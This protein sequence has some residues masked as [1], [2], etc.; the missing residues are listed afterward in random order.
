MVDIHKA[1]ADL[2]YGQFRGIQEDAIKAFCE[3]RDVFGMMATSGGKSLCYQLPAFAL[4]GYS[5]VISPLIAL[6]ND[7]ADGMKGRGIP[8]IALTPD[9][10]LRQKIDAIQKAGSETKC[11]FISPELMETPH[12]LDALKRN[13]PSRAVMDE[14]HCIS[15]WGADFRPS[16]ML[17]GELIDS[18]S[19]QRIPRMA[20]T[21]TA[22]K[23]A[24]GDILHYGR[25]RN[26]VELKQSLV[27]NNIQIFMKP[28]T[29]SV[30]TNI[31]N[32]CH[33]FG[34]ESG[35]IYC[36]RRKDV[37]ALYEEMSAAGLK[38]AKH[39]SGMR[40]EERRDAAIQFM[41]GSRRIMI[42]TM[43]FGMGIDKADVRFVI[44]HTLSATPEN[45]FQEIGR[46]GRD[47]KPCHAI[48]YVPPGI[49]QAIRLSTINR[50]CGWGVARDFTAV[51][52]GTQCRM[53][54]IMSLFGETVP[55]CGH[56]DVCLKHT[57]S[58]FPS[59]D[60]GILD[61]IQKHDVSPLKVAKMMGSEDHWL[62]VQDTLFMNGLLDYDI[63]PRGENLP[64]S[65]RLSLTAGGWRSL[66][67]SEELTILTPETAPE[68]I[69]PKTRGG[70]IDLVKSR[71]YYD[72]VSLPEGFE[73]YS[74]ALRPSA[75]DLRLRLKGL[76]ERIVAMLAPREARTL[77]EHTQ[78][79][80]TYQTSKTIKVR[81]LTL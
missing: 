75:D 77:S 28:S 69:Y 53:S 61:V 10:S 59:S 12:V 44:H 47:G 29:G 48:S 15:T 37:D 9:L 51:A 39:H 17:V 38:C 35:I 62:R 1:L 30:H 79:N 50:A 33:Y 57:P 2:G 52:L 42:A 20:L 5:L 25:F 65:A 24:I 81:R 45:W 4:P 31:I 63:L 56:C 6:M 21:A 3:G 23:E 73:R 16:Y 68:P 18:L 74:L 46:G 7:Q 72:N 80:R 43:G 55:P 41:N 34:E 67:A 32:D 14:A 60:N 19:R 27:R 36:Q 71:G 26:P 70:V 22:S 58:Q 76:P 40:S 78:E 11:V 49:S 13:P 54:S 64:P 8:A 66:R